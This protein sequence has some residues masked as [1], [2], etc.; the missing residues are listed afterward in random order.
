MVST[1]ETLK[2]MERA[3]EKKAPP[4]PRIYVDVVIV[5]LR[6]HRRALIPI[7]DTPKDTRA[8]ATLSLPHIALIINRARN[9]TVHHIIGSFFS[10]LD[11]EKKPVV[12]GVDPLPNDRRRAAAFPADARGG[13]VCVCMTHQKV[14]SAV[15]HLR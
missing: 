14:G 3:E 12:V 1:K 4:R 15:L 2:K 9:T 5:A 6:T 11:A 8:Y 7:E 13:V 10:T